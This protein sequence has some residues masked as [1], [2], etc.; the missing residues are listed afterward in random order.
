MMGSLEKHVQFSELF[1]FF[2]INRRAGK[3]HHHR[4]AE[5]SALS[6]PTPAAVMKKGQ[7]TDVGSWEKGKSWGRGE[8]G[9]ESRHR[10]ASN[11]W[12]ERERDLEKQTPY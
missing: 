12:G 6:S 9:S 11:H 8:G 10:A 5:E 7:I 2:F 4:Y 3:H 1:F